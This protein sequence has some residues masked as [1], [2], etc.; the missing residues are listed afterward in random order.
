MC[1]VPLPVLVVAITW[2]CVGLVIV[3][4]PPATVTVIVFHDNIL[5]FKSLKRFELPPYSVSMTV[6]ISFFSIK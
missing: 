3:A 6:I 5:M 1:A 2:V 4:L